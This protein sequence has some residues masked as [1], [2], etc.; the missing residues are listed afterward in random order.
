MALIKQFTSKEEF[1][2]PTSFIKRVKEL[3]VFVSSLRPIEESISTVGGVDIENLNNDFSLKETPTI[4][5]V[6]EMVDWD[7]PTGGFLLQGCFSMAYTVAN[8]INLK[9]P[10]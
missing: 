10:S 3:S 8:S 6:G 4:Y 5:T 1:L 2:D 7:A 9:L